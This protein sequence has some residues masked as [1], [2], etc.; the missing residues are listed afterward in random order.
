MQDDCGRPFAAPGTMAWY[1]LER[2][3]SPVL[4]TAFA[5]VGASEPPRRGDA[6]AVVDD[7]GFVG[8]AVATG[9]RSA[10]MTL[11][12]DAPCPNEYPARWL[13]KPT[14]E[15]SG[16][17][18]AIGPHGESLR[19][20]RRLVPAPIRTGMIELE[21][22]DASVP[23]PPVFRAW[24]FTGDGVADFEIRQRRC[25]NQRAVVEVVERGNVTRRI[26]TTLPAGE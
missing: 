8:I 15:T 14:R 24:D 25:S 1:S 21:V 13:E 10:P 18:D 4:S 3:A 16:E 19:A 26:V 2:G 17:L 12:Y 11:C 6:F 23:P 7:E 22:A 9:A 20:I 5:D